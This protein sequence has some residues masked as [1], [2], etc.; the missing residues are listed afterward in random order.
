MQRSL[1]TD[2]RERLFFFFAFFLLLP[3]QSGPL[4]RLIE[5]R[6]LGRCY[7]ATL[8]YTSIVVMLE[9]DHDL[10]RVHTQ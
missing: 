9:C 6:R 1:R 2:G 8:P 3:L 5:W 10:V 4:M 7:T